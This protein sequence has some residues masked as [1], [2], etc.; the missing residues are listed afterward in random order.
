MESLPAR[1]CELSAAGRNAVQPHWT[2]SNR[3]LLMAVGNEDFWV[4]EGSQRGF[5][6]DAQDEV[7]FGRTG[8]RFRIAIRP[9]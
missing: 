7:V 2:S 6:S 4:S 8:L 3:R 9:S 1:L 5:C